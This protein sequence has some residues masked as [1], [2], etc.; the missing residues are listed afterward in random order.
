MKMYLYCIPVSCLYKLFSIKKNYPCIQLHK[1]L[2]NRALGQRFIFP[3]SLTGVFWRMGLK[4]KDSRGRLC[5]KHR[6]SFYFITVKGQLLSKLCAKYKVNW[7]DS[8]S[9][10]RAQILVVCPNLIRHFLYHSKGKRVFSFSILNVKNHKHTVWCFFFSDGR[11]TYKL[12]F[13]QIIRNW[14]DCFYAIRSHSFVL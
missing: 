14:Q 9:V 5:F 8:L 12:T 6:I 2:F 11:I 13:C 3:N 7:Q 4:L 10:C 1:D